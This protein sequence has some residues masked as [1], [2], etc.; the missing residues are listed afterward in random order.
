[1]TGRGWRRGGDTL[2][3]GRKARDHGATPC[4][5]RGSSPKG[6]P[7]GQPGLA[8]PG[9]CR[10]AL[11][12]PDPA[13]PG[14]VRR[15]VARGQQ[16]CPA[17]PKP[18]LSEPLD[19]ISPGAPATPAGCSAGGSEPAEPRSPPSPSP[20]LPGH[21]SQAGRAARNKRSL[22]S[23]AS[24]AEPRRE[25]SLPRSRVGRML[26][27]PTAGGGPPEPPGVPVRRRGVGAR[28]GQPGGPRCFPSPRRRATLAQLALCDL[29]PGEHH[30]ESERAP[31]SPSPPRY[32]RF[33]GCP[34]QPTDLIEPRCTP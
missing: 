5:P 13:A 16:L 32:R 8:P 7:R 4:R 14:P 19:V 1:M 21:R 26:G 23:T 22:I 29:H 34:R 18:S 15:N 3:L 31:P 9:T 17:A 10:R 11:G 25:R 27:S 28:R 24:R 2:V 33:P 20:L 6:H 12:D 30:R